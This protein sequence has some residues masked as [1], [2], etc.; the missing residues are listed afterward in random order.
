MNHVKELIEDL[1]NFRQFFPEYNQKQLY[2]TVVGMEI[3]EGVGSFV[4]PQFRFTIA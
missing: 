3:E 2:G 4:I 1:G